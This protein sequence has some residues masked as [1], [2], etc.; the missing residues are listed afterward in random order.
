ME[1][2]LKTGKTE[3]IAVNRESE[4]SSSGIGAEGWRMIIIIRFDEFDT[5][6]LEGVKQRKRKKGG[7][8]KIIPFTGKKKREEQKV[9]NRRLVWQS[10]WM[11]VEYIHGL[12][13]HL[14]FFYFLFL[15]FCFER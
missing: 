12:G 13:S 6:R 1:G 9:G 2:G 10:C 7:K 8:E 11:G 5:I 4:N 3:C 15:V 14:F